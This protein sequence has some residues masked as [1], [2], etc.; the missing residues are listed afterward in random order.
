[1]TVTFTLFFSA[2]TQFFLNN[3][4]SKDLQIGIT[5]KGQI[6]KI[7]NFNKELAI[8]QKYGGFY[9]KRAGKTKNLLP[10][11]SFEND[12]NANRI[13][14]GW[15]PSFFDRKRTRPKLIEGVAR[16]G[17]R[18]LLIHNKVKKNSRLLIT[19][20]EVEPN[21]YYFLTGWVK[22]ENITPTAPTALS[23]G[24]I[25][26][27]QIS[28]N[29]ISNGKWIGS[30]NAYGY[31]GSNDWHKFGV[32]IYTDKKTT[33]LKVSF[34]LKD[35]AGK[36]Y[37]DDFYLGKLFQDEE[38]PVRSNVVKE[39]E[40][41]SWIQKA[42]FPRDK[43]ILSA[44]YSVKSDAIEVNAQVTT[45]LQNDV[46][47]KLCFVLPIDANGWKW[48]DYV[49]SSRA[50]DTYKT[51]YE[52]ATEYN[53]SIMSRYP[54]NTIYSDA[55]SISIG[56]NIS[57]PRVQKSWV[58]DSGFHTCISLGLS[59]TASNFPSSAN[60]SFV[61]YT[62]N[63][64]WGYRSAT[65]R[66]YKIFS[67]AFK[68]RIDSSREGAWFISPRNGNE[69][70]L[71]HPKNISVANDYGLS[72]NMIRFG[73]TVHQAN[74]TKP[75]PAKELKWSQNSNKLSMIYSHQWIYRKTF[76]TIDINEPE[77]TAFQNTSKNKISRDFSS[78]ASRSIIKD[79]NGRF[80]Y[81]LY[82]AP[83]SDQYV[84]QY[85]QNAGYFDKSGKLD[86]SDAIFKNH[87]F[88]VIDNA[89][90]FKGRIDGFHLDSLSG[91]RRWG[92][93]DNYNEDHWDT[94][95]LPLTFS[96]NT[97]QVT[98]NIALSNYAH[99]SKLSDYLRNNGYFLSANYNGSEARAGSWFAADK[100]DY[101]GIEQ[102]LSA[103][104][105]L[106]N[107]LFVTQD[108][109]AMYKRTIAYKR[110]ISSLNVT[111]F[112][113]RLSLD[114]Q[115][116]VLERSLFY[117]IWDGFSAITPKVNKMMQNQDIRSLYKKY[118][119]IIERLTNVGW[120]PVSYADSD[121]VDIWLER[122]GNLSDDEMF[123]VL[124]NETKDM[125]KGIIRIDKLGLNIEGEINVSKLN[126]DDGQSSHKLESNAKTEVLVSLKPKETVVLS[127]SK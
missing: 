116:S 73:L 54:F 124:R 91:M 17:N 109:F 69:K 45:D 40:R 102:Q 115:I 111:D 61:L 7:N 59:R 27:V 72:M 120:E 85:Y 90:R 39:S 106:S 52:Y 126:L 103:K 104:S 53:E 13:P 24:H 119:P 121:N 31:T 41:N 88:H 44:K 46:P 79:I 127:L 100:I 1:M 2:N 28:L 48:A 101:F 33:H 74:F 77:K 76:D 25:S 42:F 11:P 36:V 75:E 64:K 14:D 57:N 58:D 84:F 23:W 15:R 63:P 71:V 125:Q 123:L 32:G 117:G 110:P 49:R 55:G 37:F 5:E 81:E 43:I 89:R 18:S 93:A 8:L 16:T 114:D 62:S 4:S 67:E 92:E 82:K 47:L 83:R 87:I 68:R 96:Y 99:I 9:L 56:S 112:L 113:A 30:K 105:S 12:R 29:K 35:G 95:T 108:S 19:D 94:T 20:V 50:I 78:A 97:G 65:S 98:Q 34:N 80:L 107:D 51:K 22:T 21:T 38:L 3:I 66:Y 26:P 10:N 118:T 122:Y 6:T 86:W 60:A 70:S